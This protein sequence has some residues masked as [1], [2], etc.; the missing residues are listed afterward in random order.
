MDRGEPVTETGEPLA[1][2]LESLTVA[3]DAHDPCIR[4]ALQDRLAVPAHPQ[5]GV[6][7]DGTRLLEGRRQQL[8]NAVEQDGDVPVLR[9]PASVHRASFPWLVT[10]LRGTGAKYCRPCGQVP[11]RFWGCGPISGK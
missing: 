9:C 1:G 11:N 3:V 6:H 10:V 8:H 2:Q 4:A 7:H 5:C